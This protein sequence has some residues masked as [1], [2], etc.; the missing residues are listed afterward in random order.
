MGEHTCAVAVDFVADGDI[1]AQYGD[2]LHARPSADGAVPADDCAL[3]P[4][5][6]LDLAVLKQ[7]GALQAHTFANFNIR[8]NDHVGSN[9]AVLA[10]LRRRVDH[11]VTTIDVWLASGCE[12]FAALLGKG[13]EV[14]TSSREEILGLTDI[15]PETFKVEAVELA[16]L[17]DRREGLL[18]DGGGA[19]LNAIE[20]GHG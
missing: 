16:I 11:D 8:S 5:V 3:H 7:H 6:L 1:V 2:I 9:L 20:D 13:R 18:L 12:E 19:Q 15:H 17:D 14:E 10:N 4:C